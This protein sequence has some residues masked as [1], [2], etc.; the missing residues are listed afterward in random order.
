MKTRICFLMI[1]LAFS[2]LFMNVTLAESDPS[3]P[4]LASEAAI[5][6][7]AE[8]GDV[9]YEKNAGASMYPASLTKIATAIYVIETAN[10]DDTVTVSGNARQAEGSSVFLEEDEQV[11]LEKLVQGLLINSGNDAGVAI[12]EHVG[13]SVEQFV[14]DMN[15]YLQNKIGVQ[16]THFENPH[17]LFDSDHVTTAQDLATITEYAIRNE[18]FRD[19]F[20]T[21]ELEWDGKSWDTT[22]LTHHKLMREMPYE[23]VNGGKTGF[24]SQSG[25]TLATTA[26]RDDLNLIVITLNT[27]LQEEVYQDTINLLDYGF[28]NFK[29]SVIEE[30][31]TFAAGNEEYEATETLTYTQ[32]LDEQVSEEV[33]DDGLLK[34]TN[35]DGQVISSFKLEDADQETS[36]KSAENDVKGDSLLGSNSLRIVIPFVVVTIGILIIV[37]RWRR[38]QRQ[39]KRIFM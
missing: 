26:K 5:M 29:Q 22:L 19:I 33:S 21:V 14:S 37:C 2:P 10:L 12:A 20:G 39:E 28:A 16:D 9:L 27:N 35:Q 15:G 32:K 1:I 30:G 36:E 31:T 18:T 3:E 23:G 7:D 6:I 13:G 34:L 25:H 24:V 8:T 17:G 38:K 11:A 4:S